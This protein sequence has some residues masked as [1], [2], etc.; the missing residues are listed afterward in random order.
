MNLSQITSGHSPDE[1]FDYKDPVRIYAGGQVLPLGLGAR[2][3]T[4]SGCYWVVLP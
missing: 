2:E 3:H 1:W 4:Q